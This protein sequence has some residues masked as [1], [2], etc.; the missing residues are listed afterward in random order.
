[1]NDTPQTLDDVASTP[2]LVSLQFLSSSST[3]L[4]SNRTNL[5]RRH[6]LSKSQVLNNDEIDTE[7]QENKNIHNTNKKS[8]VTNPTT[9]IFC[10]VYNQSSSP[11]SPSPILSNRTCNQV[12]E[13]LGSS[14]DISINQPISTIL[15][16]NSHLDEVEITDND[17]VPI[18]RASNQNRFQFATFSYKQLD[19]KTFSNSN[20]VSLLQQAF[21]TNKLSHSP[22]KPF[23]EFASENFDSV[24]HTQNSN[25]IPHSSSTRNQETF[26]LDNES[27]FTKVE[28][29]MLLTN[30]EEEIISKQQQNKDRDKQLLPDDNV[31]GVKS[32][33]VDKKAS[34][35]ELVQNKT[36]RRSTRNKSKQP[37]VSPPENDEILKNESNVNNEKSESEET[38]KTKPRKKRKR[39]PLN[40]TTASHTEQAVGNNKKK[41]TKT[42]DQNSNFQRL[43]MKKKRFSRAKQHQFSKFKRNAFRR[44]MRNVCFV[45]KQDG[46]W[47]NDCPHQAARTNMMNNENPSTN[48]T[49]QKAIIDELDD[50]CIIDA[51]HRPKFVSSYW[52]IDEKAD[53]RL[54]DETLKLFGHDNFRPQQLEAIVNIL[55]GQSTIV[56]LP[57]GF[58]KTLIYQ[59]P[60]YLYAK[61]SNSITL[62]ISPL[63]SLMED[64]LINT[65]NCLSAA[66]I[67]SL[68]QPNEIDRVL[69]RIV[70]G[71]VHL[72]LISPEMITRSNR[73]LNAGIPPIAF[74]CI[75]EV[76][77]ISHW[78]HN[79]RPSYLQVCRVLRERY[80]VQCFL[81]LTATATTTTLTDIARYLNIE[82][83]C[84]TSIIRGNVVRDNL[85]LTVSR[86][87]NKDGA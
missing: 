44:R 7:S 23:E 61:R 10:D 34:K 6:N 37:I 25:I 19:E 45:C 42:V 57:T 24:F 5:K 13:R 9:P 56:V 78:S 64:Q 32:T 12:W 52:S 35:S 82:Q 60:A 84:E 80:S 4:R 48:N 74:C 8:F 28:Q 58:G 81:G 1:M 27:T 66:S 79:F 72:L 36:A 15:S 33:T 41:R 83:S 85:M 2:K 20:S 17:Y 70:H 53:Q 21:T 62:V 63:V 51:G 59:L 22:D 29:E 46:H 71:T 75:D 3:S 49:G 26:N 87:T 30:R 69:D 18:N 14:E 54:L 50:P 47:A 55:R 40:E 68:M 11:T 43:N 86:D 73:L 65:A 39:S 38:L 67:H 76:H 31:D 16:S 77:C